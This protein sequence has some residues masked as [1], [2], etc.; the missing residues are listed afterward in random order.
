[1]LFPAIPELHVMAAAAER[2]AGNKAG[3]IKSTRAA[4]RQDP[5]RTPLYLQLADLFVEVNQP[6]SVVVALATAPRQGEQAALLRTYTVARGLMM[7]RTAGDTLPALQGTA[8]TLL[9]LAD[10]MESREDSRSYVAAAALQRSR[11][12]L[13]TASKSRSCIDVQR[14]AATLQLAMAAR[15]AGLGTGGNATEIIS[16][17]DA[18]RTAVDNGVAVLCKPPVPYDG[19]TK[20][21]IGS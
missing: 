1:M 6:D 13:L 19:I 21:V 15:D 20:R 9:V 4:I 5:S 12:E 17:Y 18:M 11:A 3:A 16:A 8:L 10:S 2:K 7:L 14:A